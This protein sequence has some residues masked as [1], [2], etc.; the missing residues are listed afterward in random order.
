MLAGDSLA[1]RQRLGPYRVE[2]ILGAGGMGVVFRG[3]APDGTAVALKAIRPDLMDPEVRARFD[4]EATIR[5]DH[6]N[7]IRV[8][9]TGVDAGVPYIALELLEGQSL[10]ARLEAEGR[11]APDVVVPLLLQAC[12][13]LGAAHRLGIV[14]R[15]LKPAN[16]FTCANGTLKVLDFG[17]AR[18][19]GA[20]RLTVAAGVLGT[21]AYLSPEQARG[22]PDIDGRS[23]VW[24]LGV[25]AYEA[26][27][28][29]LPF[30]RSVPIAILLA[31]IQDDPPPLDEIV[32]GLPPSL[33]A[34]V[35]RCLAR[36][37]ED[38]F[39]SVEALADALRNLDA[40]VAPAPRA[41]PALTLRAD[42]SR[43]VVVLLARRVK[44]LATVERE[45]SAL[46]GVAIPLLGREVLGVFGAPTWHGDES[47]RCARAAIAIRHLAQHVSMSSG[48]AYAGSGGVAGEA[49]AEAQRGGEIDLEGVAVDVA[50]AAALRAGFVL[51]EARVGFLELLGER[52]SDPDVVDADLG[53]FVGR[54]AELEL[55]TQTIARARET[56]SIVIVSGPAGIGKSRILQ[57]AGRIVRA[58]DPSAVTFLARGEHLRRDSVFGIFAS[59]LRRHARR[60]AAQLGLPVLSVEA[61]PL[62]RRQAALALVREAIP[63]RDA[64]WAC[65]EFL[66]ELLGVACSE[67]TAVLDARSNP[68][69]MTDRVRM[70]L[71]DYLRAL[72]RRHPVA[73][74]FEDVHWADASSLAI[75][76]TLR[77]SSPALPFFALLTTRE[78][79]MPLAGDGVVRVALAGLG[80]DDT[81]TLA[82][83]AVGRS[84]SATWLRSLHARTEGNPFFVEQ[85]ATRAAEVGA[86]RSDARLPFTV[87]AVIQ[88]R[89]DGL[90]D[91][92]RAACRA[93]GVYGRAIQMGELAALG[94]RDPAESLAEL[95]GR[96]LVETDVSGGRSGTIEYRFRSA[97]VPAVAYRTI[98]PEL[99]GDLHRRAAEYVARR[100]GYD[101][102]EVGTHF[103]RAGEPV[104]AAEQFIIGA[105][106][107]FTRADAEGVL[108]CSERSLALGVSDDARFALYMLRAETFQFLRRRAEQAEALSRALAVAG[109][110]AEKARVLT[111][112]IALAS[113]AGDHAAAARLAV[114]AVR[115]ADGSGDPEACALARVRYA[116]ALAL[117]GAH[118]NA[119]SW[120]ASAA[121]A[122]ARGSR[123]RALVAE[124]SALV[125]AARG[126]L[127]ANISG[128]MEAAGLYSKAGDVR[129]AAAVE[130]NLADAYNRIG[131]YDAAEVA[132]TK[133]LEGCRRVGNRIYEGYALANLGYAY[134]RRGRADEALSVLAVAASLAE[135]ARDQ[136]LAAAVQLYQARALFVARR[137]D[138]AMVAAE[139]GA[140]LARDAGI[141][142]LEASADALSAQVALALG[143]VDAALECS[144]RALATRDALGSVGEDE[145]E[146]YLARVDALRSAGRTA[147]AEQT[148]ALGA[149]RVRAMSQGIADP[150]WRKHFERAVEAHRRLLEVP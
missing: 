73:L 131:A 120:I 143:R 3:R 111:D 144:G 85:I 29:K 81:R 116:Q 114:D 119:S 52:S 115:E 44:D 27:S 71:L 12:A 24:A 11:L 14:H 100:P 137:F 77:A 2:G 149:A 63:D 102:E 22:A 84:L 124:V 89:L 130:G 105:R 78:A 95:A 49:L 6:P 117:A 93:A 28:G 31:I 32:S 110:P 98:P 122:G 68:E 96:E 123:V 33:V 91:D 56:S 26:L 139:Q 94:V 147:E 57:E 92:A 9:D 54:A 113:R 103:E 40:A 140:Q 61:P 97:L 126:D 19:A 141:G 55:V 70:A 18:V 150:E 1:G 75:I 16:L 135:D 17:I 10:E 148:R 36:R 58:S 142:A 79:A 51:Q 4:R 109:S 23:D 134:A 45:I 38:R 66:A 108:R 83:R 64:A 125:A 47:M 146:I 104:R 59:A 20:A 67:S 107:A 99:V 13:G 136:R 7:I 8:I 60:R 88:S 76:D 133:A 132:L 101:A 128:F 121:S 80:V 145:G 127:G 46:G 118:Q 37:A 65:A 69:L 62:A 21:L 42:E 25:V 106:D 112:Q 72:C 129:R 5:I 138:D 90:P 48:T 87:E 39:E 74:L 35:A 15:D 41:A 34:I 53:L 30:E 86:D 82:E 43:V 50:T